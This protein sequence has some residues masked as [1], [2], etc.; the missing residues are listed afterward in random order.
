MAAWGGDG[1]VWVQLWA[2]SAAEAAAL[3]GLFA[4]NPEDLEIC[5]PGRNV[6]YAAPGFWPG[7]ADFK[8]SP[9]PPAP[10]ATGSRCAGYSEKR[11]NKLAK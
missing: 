11:K 1:R 9:L 3:G 8:A 7:A 2:G 4:R 5:R 10:K 6:P